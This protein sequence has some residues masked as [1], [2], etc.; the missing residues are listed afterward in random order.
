MAHLLPYGTCNA[1]SVKLYPATPFGG[2]VIAW[3]PRYPYG[4]LRSHI[5]AVSLEG[6]G[7][8]LALD[9]EVMTGRHLSKMTT[10]RTDVSS[11]AT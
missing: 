8:T 3:Q 7:Q 2:Q 4:E 1:T 10:R 11:Y 5:V 9:P 6:I